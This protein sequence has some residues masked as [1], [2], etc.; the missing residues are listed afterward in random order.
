MPSCAQAQFRFVRRVAADTAIFT[1][2]FGD[3]RFVRKGCVS[4]RFVG[5]ASALAKRT[6]GLEG[7][8]GKRARARG[9][10]GKRRRCEDVRM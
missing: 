6:R 1:L 7:Q 5:T 9:R 10:E 8:E 2:V 4:W 3:S